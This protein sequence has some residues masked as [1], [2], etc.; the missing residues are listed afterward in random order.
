MRR[1]RSLRSSLLRSKEIPIETVY[2][3]IRYFNRDGLEGEMDSPYN[4]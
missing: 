3:Y 2:S 4:Q 1:S